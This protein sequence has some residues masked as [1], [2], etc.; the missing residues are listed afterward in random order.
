ML[1]PCKTKQ[2]A[3]VSAIN[4]LTNKILVHYQ[5]VRHGL[6]SYKSWTENVD[7]IYSWGAIDVCNDKDERV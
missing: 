4:K 7:K 6:C 1:F 2:L 5:K 3:A